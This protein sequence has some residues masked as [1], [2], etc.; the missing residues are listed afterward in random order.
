MDKTEE[1]Q[2]SEQEVAE[3][4]RLAIETL[5][6]QRYCALQ[7]M[8]MLQGALSSESLQNEDEK[9]FWIWVAERAQ[10]EKAKLKDPAEAEN[11][12]TCC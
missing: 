8:G 3:L 5:D 1:A 4:E 2:R 10:Q 11:D 7:A 9:E 12:D 6:T